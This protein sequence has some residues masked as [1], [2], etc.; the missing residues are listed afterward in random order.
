MIKS[1]YS[2]NKEII[3]NITKIY[4]NI[5]CDLTYNRGTFYKDLKR[6]KYKFDIAPKNTE[7]IKSDS[8]FIPVKDNKFKVIMFDPPFLATTGKSLTSNDGNNIITKRFDVFPNEQELHKCQDKVSS[9]KQYMSHC[10][11]WEKAVEIG[12][13][14]KD[15]FILIARNRI[16]ADWQR[17]QKHARKFHC[18]FWVFQKKPINIKYD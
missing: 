12:W 7:T 15:L 4:G 14:P 13:Y 1:V 18:Y 3:Y 2:S 9:G 11:V 6:P 8:R 10:F 16:V 5:D 17:N